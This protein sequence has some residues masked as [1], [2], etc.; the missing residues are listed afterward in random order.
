MYVLIINFF[1]AEFYNV[2]R[3]LIK[4]FNAICYLLEEIFLHMNMLIRY[5]CRT[6]ETVDRDTDTQ[7]LTDNNRTLKLRRECQSPVKIFVDG[8]NSKGIY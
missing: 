3:Y 5:V 6:H 1:C 8:R 2:S 4:G 7:Q